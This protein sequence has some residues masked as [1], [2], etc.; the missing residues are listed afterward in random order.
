MLHHVAR[1]DIT[2]IEKR[3]ADVVRQMRE[4]GIDVNDD[5]TLKVAS[6]ER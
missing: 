3:N 2:R 1:D 6:P 4:R 5:G